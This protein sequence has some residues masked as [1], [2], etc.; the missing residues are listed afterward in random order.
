MNKRILK[1]SFLA[2]I[3]VSFLFVTSC[4]DD[5]SNNNP[6]SQEITQAEVKRGLEV[7]R[8]S[9]FID[10]LS[11]DNLSMNRSSSKTNSRFS[12]PG[13]PDFSVTENGYTLTFDNCDAGDGE[14]INGTI[15]VS[16][17]IDNN[18]TTST[19]TFDNLTFGGNTL[20]GSKTT[21]YTLNTTDGGSFSYSV[22]S[23]LSITFEDGTTAS[24]S[25]TKTY[26]IT[27]LNSVDASYTIT[28]NWTVT[29]G[30]DSY[31]LSTDPSLQG[32]FSCDY[33][34]T[35]TLIMTENGVSASINFG[36]GTCDNL[37]TVTYPDGTSEEIEL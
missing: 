4:S 8:I 3:L 30:D 20:N 29:I 18:T 11:I 37:A 23:D 33:I 13:C 1:I 31:S 15:N 22:T 19:I 26:E 16:I 5:D 35:G 32:T 10:G 2:T 14:I 6:Q 36:D 17:V 25:G 24:E 7:D 34:T 21:S 28:G 27:D 9:N 12:Q